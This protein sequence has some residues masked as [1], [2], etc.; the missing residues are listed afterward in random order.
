MSFKT[1]T[2]LVTGSCGGLGRAISEAFLAEG[3]NVVV[4]D[5][6]QEL[7]ADFTD[8]VSAAYPN[9]TL[10]LDTDVTNESALDDLFS[11]AESAFGRVDFVVNCAGML[12][13]TLT[14]LFGDSCR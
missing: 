13:R 8:N 7:I 6:K 4:C 3:A 11:Q 1:K 2:A 5:V 12:K 10:V 9:R 14:I